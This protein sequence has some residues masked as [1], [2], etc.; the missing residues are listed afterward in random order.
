[1]S[2]FGWLSGQAFTVLGQ[3]VIWSDMIGNVLGLAALALGWRRS[4]WTWPAQLASGLILVIAYLTAHLGGGTGKQLIVITVA[5]W[6]WPA[7]TDI[8]PAG[9][10]GRITPRKRGSSP[11]SR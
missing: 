7:I 1:M 9:S 6:G 11:S 4:M 10:P 8:S 5:L 2:A 3:H